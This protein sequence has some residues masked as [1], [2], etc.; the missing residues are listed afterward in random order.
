M[1]T[2]S[3]KPM[4]IYAWAF[5]FPMTTAEKN[6]RAVIER[7]RGICQGCG[8]AG[9]AV[10]HIIPRSAPFPELWSVKNMVVLC[11]SCHAR[12]QSRAARVWLFAKLAR[13]WAYVYD[14]RPFSQYVT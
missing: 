4:R 9:T 14:Y 8:A 5:L 7:D 11:E 13:L 1:V 2:V 3:P 12:A 6:R 10:H